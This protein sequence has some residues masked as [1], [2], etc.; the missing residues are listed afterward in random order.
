MEQLDSFIGKPVDVVKTELESKGYK[1]VVKENSLP[2]I[3]TDYKL[4]VLA[5]NIDDK[6]IELIVGDF[7][8]NIENKIN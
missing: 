5:K 6:V 4:I 1:V 3:Q 8:I 7:L 2:K